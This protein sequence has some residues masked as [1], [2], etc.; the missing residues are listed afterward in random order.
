MRGHLEDRGKNVWRA[1]VYVGRQPDGRRIYVTRTIHGNKRFAE[2]RLAEL[3]RE[4]GTSDQVVTDGT[5]A[6]LVEKWRPIAELNLSPTTLR[7]YDRLLEKRILPR[8][9][10]TKVRAIRAADIDAFY[11]QLQRRGRADG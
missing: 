1:K 11:A 8:F 3:L 4:A 7:E 5:L 10:A 9:G 2:E 6:E